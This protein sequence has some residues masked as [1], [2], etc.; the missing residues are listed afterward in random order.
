MAV[1]RC[2]FCGSIYDE[3]K[4]GVPVS[5]LKS[6]SVCMVTADKLVKAED[7][8]AGA[9]APDREKEK[10]VDGTRKHVRTAAAVQGRLLPM[11]LS[12]PGHRPMPA[13]WT[14]FMR[15]L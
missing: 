6:L 11:T 3:E 5:D 15:W 2:R 14:K 8:G 1:Y 12:M 13:I 10:P 7:G 4:E 9:K